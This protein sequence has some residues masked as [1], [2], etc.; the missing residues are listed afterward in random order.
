MAFDHE[1]HKLDPETGLQVDKETGRPIGLVSPNIVKAASPDPDWPRWVVP[2]PNHVVVQN[3]RPTVP[4]FPE[5]H[6]RRH[7]GQLTVLVHNAAD[8]ATALADPHIVAADEATALSDSHVVV[9][10][11]GH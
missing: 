3:D 2:H 5:F 11:P 10:F 7:D 9:E 8:E 1:L 4:A 6:I